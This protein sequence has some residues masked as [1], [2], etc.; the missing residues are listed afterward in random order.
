MKKKTVITTEKREV[1][2][3]CRQL[4]SSQESGQES[5]V[6]GVPPPVDPQGSNRSLAVPPEQPQ[7]EDAPL[8]N[9]MISKKEFGDA[10]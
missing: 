3:I 1:W 4:D 6:E 5:S 2:V 9:E 8:E 7:P 10:Q